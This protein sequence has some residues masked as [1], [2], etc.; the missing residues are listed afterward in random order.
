MISLAF[1]SAEGWLLED[2]ATFF[3]TS[4]L[5][6]VLA[7]VDEVPPI[8]LSLDTVL[9]SFGTY[10]YYKAGEQRL[11]CFNLVKGGV[12]VCLNCL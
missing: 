3:E 4:D 12:E 7:A 11:S 10:L 8:E 1:Q 5:S 9:L 6:G 2:R